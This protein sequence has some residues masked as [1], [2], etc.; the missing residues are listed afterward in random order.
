M[1]RYVWE[2]FA[3]WAI[4]ALAL[5][6]YGYLT[7]R[8]EVKV[9]EHSVGAV[10][11]DMSTAPQVSDELDRLVVRAYREGA[12]RCAMSL[13]ERAVSL[14]DKSFGRNDPRTLTSVANLAALY[15]ENDQYTAAIP[16]YMQAI[17][18]VKANKDAVPGVLYRLRLRLA[19]AQ[20]GAGQL[21]EAEL[22]YADARLD[23]A[24]AER[25][26][27]TPVD[28]AAAEAGSGTSSADD[29]RKEAPAPAEEPRPTAALDGEAK[30]TE[31]TVFYGTDRKGDKTK[32]GERPG[33][34]Y[35]AGR[36]G[37]LAL[38]SVVVSIPPTHKF[39]NVEEPS[40]WRLEIRRDPDRHMV[41]SNVSLF[42]RAEF[43]KAVNASL[44]RGGVKEAFV[45]VHGFNMTFEDAALRTA[46]MAFDMDFR[47]APMFYSWP[48]AGNLAGYDHDQEVVA[49][50][51]PRL[52]EFLSLVAE[53]TQA[54]KVHLIAHSMGARALT[55]ALV[56]LREGAPADAAPVFD[57]ILLA[58]PDMDVEQ[59]RLIAAKVMGAGHGTTLYASANDQALRVA[60]RLK[61]GIPRLGDTGSGIVVIPGM[62]T[63]DASLVDSSF[64]GHGYFAEARSVLNDIDRLLERQVPAADRGLTPLATAQGERYWAIQYCPPSQL[65]C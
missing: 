31:V 13:G 61:Q 9:V 14:A 55:A 58:A 21:E 59:F 11:A 24:A 22:S 65:V 28:V 48:A 33:F 46:Q 38:G 49:T 27:K 7:P 53:E 64:I 60:R 54:E 16:L 3:A 6:A 43:V 23:K 12:L 4:L 45:F 17:A 26:L 44:E 34:R 63:I 37:K 20:E 1:M 35:G 57:E 15:V 40:L 56:A 62:D 51:V 5:F 18:V 30:S 29:E 2:V 19:T 32:P 42:S 52:K 10:C 36:A 47:G 39:G 25:A 41:V 8:P 50:A